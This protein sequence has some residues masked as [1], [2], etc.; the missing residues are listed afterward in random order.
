MPAYHWYALRNEGETSTWEKELRRAACQ[1]SVDH[2][3]GEQ[4]F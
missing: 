1:R 4:K 3:W 2:Y